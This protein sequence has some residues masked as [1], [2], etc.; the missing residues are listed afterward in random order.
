MMPLVSELSQSALS[1]LP[2][3]QER[4]GLFAD[5]HRPEKCA[6]QPGEVLVPGVNAGG[7]RVI[8]ARTN[9]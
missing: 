3:A 6:E 7:R 1:A 2:L 4:D 9:G 8:D 5:K